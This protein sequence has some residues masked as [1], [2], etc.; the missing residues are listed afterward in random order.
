[1]D[2]LWDIIRDVV[3][4]LPTMS[5]RHAEEDALFVLHGHTRGI[6]KYDLYPP[7]KR[8][9]NPR[10]AFECIPFEIWYE[11]F[12]YVIP[13]STFL[14][15][16]LS[17]GPR[18][19]WSLALRTKKTLVS[20]C[21]TWYNVGIHLL[22]RQIVLRRFPQI[23]FLLQSLDLNSDLGPMIKDIT[24]SCFVLCDD[25]P[26]V[27]S[28]LNRLLNY[29]PLVSHFTFAI[30]L[31]SQSELY[32][33]SDFLAAATHMLSNVTHLEF[34][35]KVFFSDVVPHL[36]HCKSLISLTFDM[37]GQTSND[38]ATEAVDLPTLEALRI[39][40]QSDRLEEI[41]VLGVITSWSM[42]RLY[43]FTIHQMGFFR[44]T[45]ERYY[46]PFL[47]KYGPALSTLCVAVW[48]PD[49]IPMTYFVQSLLEFCPNLEHLAISSFVLIEKLSH[50][51]LKWIDIWASTPERHLM[52]AQDFPMLRGVRTLD[53]A[54]LT[55]AGP[56]LHLHVPPNMVE[57]GESREWV[58]PG[59]HV[60]H[61]PGHLY[62]RDLDYLP[63]YIS[64]VEP[65]SDWESG[66]EYDTSDSSSYTDYSFPDT[67]D[68]LFRQ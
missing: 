51:T 17:C 21:K 33:P 40:W 45:A 65:I 26:L 31:Q 27:K 59:V 9:T 24:V 35:P 14:D 29:C 61:D 18:S 3:W 30:E 8:C 63:G 2:V 58:F 66:D 7:C 23:Y 5:Q 25:S 64:A 62:R 50:K 55:T 13:P 44:G 36:T 46:F 22:Y 6:T 42:P 20:V 60:R 10:Y 52:K 57:G 49:V 12:Q 28:E 48:F 4:D 43:R 37:H 56:A 1:M 19:P 16:S 15:S 68:S 41:A 67:E 39:S 32:S 11:I 53:W 38:M 47:K 54:L 34:G